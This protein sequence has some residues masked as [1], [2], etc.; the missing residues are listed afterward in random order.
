MMKQL[1][2]SFTLLLTIVFPIFGQAQ[3]LQVSSQKISGN[4][5][6]KNGVRVAF[7]R[8]K[9]LN[10]HENQNIK[11]LTIGRTGLSNFQDIGRIWAESDS[12]KR[13]HSRKL[14]AD[15]QVELTFR[16]PL[17]LQKNIPTE[18]TIYANLNFKQSGQTVS[19]NLLNINKASTETLKTSTQKRIIPKTTKLAPYDRSKYRI[20]CRNSR[21]R[22]IPRN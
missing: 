22:L 12:F 13:T 3:D 11:T 9:L 17:Q 2:I 15:D 8:L 7:L 18:I 1:L 21:C 6:P 10:T 19:L 16:S 4:T 20:K 14:S 5:L